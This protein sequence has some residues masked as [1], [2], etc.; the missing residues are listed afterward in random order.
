M[1]NIRVLPKFF[2]K[3][4]FLTFVNKIYIISNQQDVLHIIYYKYVS[5]L[6]LNFLQM[7]A[8]SSSPDEK[9]I[10]HHG[11]DSNSAMLTSTIEVCMPLLASFELT[12]PFGLCYAHVL[13]NNSIRR[14]CFVYSTI[15]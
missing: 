7:Q 5:A 1:L 11:E 8:S 2:I 13:G 4:K 3:M 15:T 9:L 12:K 14:T 10:F 6:P